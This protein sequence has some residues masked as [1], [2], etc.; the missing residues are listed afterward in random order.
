MIAKVPAALVCFILVLGQIGCAGTKDGLVWHTPIPPM[1][2]PA[3]GRNTIYVTWQD[4][5]GRDVDLQKD[6]RSTLEARG[7]K[8][9]RNPSAADYRLMA[10]LRYFDENPAR[11]QGRSGARYFEGLSDSPAGQYPK[12]DRYLLDPRRLT[13]SVE[14][15]FTLDLILAERIEGGVSE[16]IK[17]KNEQVMNRG[18]TGNATSNQATRNQ[19]LGNILNTHLVQEC[20]FTAW[21]SG[22]S[23]DKES[24]QKAMQPRILSALSQTVPSAN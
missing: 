24:A 23:F 14:W 2:P 21:V 1:T 8:I 6:I 15:N 10:T 13:D 20:A 22:T 11:D 18:R 9:E 17:A 5:T 16:E 19:S 12:D 3:D 7:Y 4:V